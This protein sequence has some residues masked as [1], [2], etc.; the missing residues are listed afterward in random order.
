MSDTLVRV[1]CQTL[2]YGYY[3]R[4]DELEDYGSRQSIVFGC[5]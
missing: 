1:F 3:C 4:Y 2:C 5:Q